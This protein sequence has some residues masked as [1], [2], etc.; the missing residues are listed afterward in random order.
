MGFVFDMTNNEFSEDDD[1]TLNT[2][3]SSE[4]SPDFIIP[5]NQGSPLLEECKFE[6][7]SDVNNSDWIIESSV[8]SS[9]THK[10]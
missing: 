5:D 6:E 3:L 7:Q 1:N 4:L 2:G 8:L 10:N 9:L